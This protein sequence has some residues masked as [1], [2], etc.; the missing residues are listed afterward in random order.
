MLHRSFAV[1]VQLVHVS[2]QL[3][4]TIGLQTKTIG[5][6]SLRVHRFGWSR[7]PVR[8]LTN[9]R[10]LCCFFHILYLDDPGVMPKSRPPATSASSNSMTSMSS[11]VCL[12]QLSAQSKPFQ[13]SVVCLFQ[14]QLSTVIYEFSLTSLQKRG[15]KA[16]T[17]VNP[18][19]ACPMETGMK[20]LIITLCVSNVSSDCILQGSA[21]NEYD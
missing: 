17:L 3:Y 20:G 18:Q 2:T 21:G 6:E 10:L 1:L 19:G 15:C 12:F 8:R 5:T 7:F 13:L 16:S 4:I 14:L 11:A 9:C